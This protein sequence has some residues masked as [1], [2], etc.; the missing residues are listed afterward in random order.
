[1]NNDKV[2]ID[3]DNYKK[4]Y[5]L[6]SQNYNGPT[7]YPIHQHTSYPIPQHTSYPIPQHTSYPI[8]GPTSYPI[9]GPTSYPIPQ[10]TSYPITGPTS[11]PVDI[12]TYPP[13][14]EQLIIKMIKDYYPEFIS[15]LGNNIKD[16]KF[17]SAIKS[18][19]NLRKIN[20]RDLEV[21]VSIL[22]P[23]QNEIDLDKSLKYP[24]T[25]PFTTELFLNGG[26]I[27]IMGQ[28]IV[29]SNYGKFI[30]DGH[31][32]WS[33]VYCINPSAKMLALD[34]SDVTDPFNALKYTQLGIAAD[35]GKTPIAPG[36]GINMLTACKEDIFKY[37]SKNIKPEVINV[38]IAKK[39]VTPNNPVPQIQEYIWGNISR[40]RMYNKPIVN[41]PS[42]EIM[43]QT[44]AAPN[45]IYNI[46]FV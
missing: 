3:Y 6:A 10:H 9:A 42:R 2:C 18:L 30:I 39:I 13:T 27:S 28:K 25:D 21:P 45:W 32:R 37:I 40:M 22:I 19:S 23:T 11:C 7:S 33:E 24:L 31:H 46:P 1:M 8:A 14:N 20:Y 35:I 29:T 43:P 17:I 16:I 44:D 41:A 4:I 15:K 36:G 26:I 34:L 5:D 12:S 38:F